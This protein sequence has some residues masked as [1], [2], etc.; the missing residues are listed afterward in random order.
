MGGES[1]SKMVKKKRSKKDPLKDDPNRPRLRSEAEEDEGSP[2][3]MTQGLELSGEEMPMPY[4]RVNEATDLIGQLAEDYRSPSASPVRDVESEEKEVEFS[5]SAWDLGEEEDDEEPSIRNSKARKVKEEMQKELGK[6]IKEQESSETD[7]SESAAGTG[8]VTGN[9]SFDSDKFCSAGAYQR[10]IVFKNRGIIGEKL[11]DLEKQKEFEYSSVI[12]EAGFTPTVSIK[13]GYDREVINEFYANLGDT[14]INDGGVMVL[15]RGRIINFSPVKIN[16]FLKMSEL[17]AKDFRTAAASDKTDPDYVAAFLKEDGS[18]EGM[19]Q[20]ISKRP[21]K[22]PALS[23]VHLSS[24]FAA[25]AIL[26][27]HNW[28]PTTH[29]THIAQYRSM[30]LYKLA[31]KVRVDFGEMV[32]QQVMAISQIERED[33]KQ[34]DS[35]KL[36]FPHLIY[37]MIQEQCGGFVSV[38]E[39]L[40]LP[41]HYQMDGRTEKKDTGASKWATR[42][43]LRTRTKTVAPVKDEPTTKKRAQSPSSQP[44]LKKKTKREPEQSKP[45]SAAQFDDSGLAIDVS[46]GHISVPLGR[47]NQKVVNKALYQITS[48]LHQ[49]AGIVRDVRQ[50]NQGGEVSD[51]ESG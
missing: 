37:G 44:V 2:A 48:V 46:L 23:T 34:A 16:T 43:S 50:A 19:V 18:H 51:D 29:R 24:K 26:A 36:V 3:F 31:Q 27:G 32:F 25:L 22:V 17:S 1:S 33:N 35:R 42:T 13:S 21:K 14:V 6:Q 11:V 7:D 9:V 4:L 5:D 28:Y 10:Y 8:S 41:T 39:V 49:L 12:A 30:L 40:V 45:S 38:D 20:V 15:V 47:S